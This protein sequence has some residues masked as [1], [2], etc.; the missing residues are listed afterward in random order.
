[1]TSTLNLRQ[2]RRR[3]ATEL[4]I[5]LLLFCITMVVTPFW[6]SV[7]PQ[8]LDEDDEFDEDDDDNEPP[9][10][11]IYSKQLK[12]H[13]LHGTFILFSHNDARTV[14]TEP[15]NNVSSCEV[16]RIVCTLPAGTPT[17]SRHST[18]QV[19]MFKRRTE[20]DATTVGFLH[21]E[22]LNE[23]HLRHLPEIV[24]MSE[25]LVI[26]SNDILNLAFVFT[27]H[28]LNDDS[29]NLFFTCQGMAFAFLLRS[30]CKKVESGLPIISDVPGGYCLPFPSAYLHSGYHD[31]YPS[32]IWNS[33][34]YLRLEMKK[35][36]G[37]YSH[38]QGLF[39]KEVCRL[40]NFTAEAWGFLCLQFFDIFDAAGCGT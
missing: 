40:S 32:R 17:S 26:S 9:I 20:F 19:N 2:I 1:M 39:C 11:S 28:V 5:H 38:L 8:E 23:N 3:S 31:C 30:R 12:A 21:S 29:C 14:G 35:L 7:E 22:F 36:L 27:P 6:D 4:P 13:L 16:A 34:M 33:I 18:V 10:R 15:S 25:M 24:Q 37:R